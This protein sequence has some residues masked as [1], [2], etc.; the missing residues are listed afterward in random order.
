MVANR[1]A[2]QP[3]RSSLLPDRG[4]SFT[5]KRESST[6]FSGVR[7]VCA[8]TGCEVRRL[9]LSGGS[10]YKCL[11]IIVLVFEHAKTT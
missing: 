6:L 5:E 11:I 9:T 1:V 3:L 2:K 4:C 8:R 7:R 10:G